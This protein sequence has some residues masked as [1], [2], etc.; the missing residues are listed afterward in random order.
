MA[1]Q[2]ILD[3]HSPIKVQAPPA[4]LE[5]E[6]LVGPQRGPG[7]LSDRIAGVIEGATPAWW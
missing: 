7:W 4:A 5:R 3:E 6:P 1:V 2:P